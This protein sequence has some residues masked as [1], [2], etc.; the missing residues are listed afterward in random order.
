MR[1]AT[2]NFEG[3]RALVIGQGSIG[4]RH[5]RILREEGADVRTVSARA[6]D[7]FPSIGAAW[8]AAPYDYA[9][10]ANETAKHL[11][12][13]EALVL[14]GFEGHLLVE[15]PLA[16]SAPQKSLA[17]PFRK[18]GVAYNLRFHPV[19]TA[20]KAELANASAVEVR[21]HV[22]QYLP[23]WRPGT[24]F[25]KGSS[26]LLASGGGV[27][28]DLSHELDL[29]QHLFGPW[30]RL[31]AVGGNRGVLNIE[32][33]EMWS[34]LFELRSGAIVTL[35]MNYYDR[36]PERRIAVTTASGSIRADLIGGSLAAADGEEKFSVERDTTYRLQHQA[37]LDNANSTVCSFGEAIEVL[38]TIAAIEASAK[39]SIWVT[40]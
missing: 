6:A 12:S 32:T 3:V 14:L 22:G 21:M 40:R 16:R 15:K 10:V 38:S 4:Q 25:R 13:V 31:V 7:A 11:E 23:D 28:R 18:S 5:A 34:V 30:R 9:V 1:V 19:I 17:A 39:N 35:T 36:M 8:A 2:S 33:D 37:M 20:L 26:A 27:L 29:L 24:D